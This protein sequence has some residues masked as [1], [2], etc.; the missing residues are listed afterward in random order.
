MQWKSPSKSFFWRPKSTESRKQTSERNENKHGHTEFAHE[1][2]FGHMRDGD[3]SRRPFIPGERFARTTRKHPPVTL[4]MVQTSKTFLLYS[5][6]LKKYERFKTPFEKSM[7]RS[8]ENRCCVLI[9]EVKKC[10]ALKI[11]LCCIS[12]TLEREVRCSRINTSRIY[13]FLHSLLAS[14]GNLLHFPFFLRT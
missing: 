6:A 5:M 2:P 11:G 8:L 10:G 7:H 1:A 13:L 3:V 14:N 9:V 4:S 12:C